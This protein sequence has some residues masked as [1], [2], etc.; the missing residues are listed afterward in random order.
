MTLYIR[1]VPNAADYSAA[2]GP[3]GVGAGDVDNLEGSRQMD[4][5]RGTTTQTKLVGQTPSWLWV[6]VVGAVL[7]A[8]A[9]ASAAVYGWRRNM[10]GIEAAG[11]DGAQAVDVNPVDD[12]EEGADDRAVA[13]ASAAKYK[14]DVEDEA[15][16]GAGAAPSESDLDSIEL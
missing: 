16:G 9:L 11:V 15:V 13:P 8:A 6:V 4:A 10:R 2:N 12:E 7:V 14:A 3:M 5:R 1:L